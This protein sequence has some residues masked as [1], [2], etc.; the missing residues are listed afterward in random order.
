[1]DEADFIARTLTKVVGRERT[2]TSI[3]ETPTVPTTA[4]AFVQFVLQVLPNPVP[5]RD[6]LASLALVEAA[7]A[8]ARAV[9]ARRA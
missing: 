8:T 3:P 7:Y 5:G 1:M 9:Q 4:A 2:V 6:A